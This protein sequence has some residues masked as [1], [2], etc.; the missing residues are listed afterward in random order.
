MNKTLKAILS[1]IGIVSK[2]WVLAMSLVLLTRLYV[3]S[4]LPKGILA[5]FWFIGALLFTLEYWKYIRSK[6]ARR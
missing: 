5:W 2:T 3:A 6:G 1:A 4:D